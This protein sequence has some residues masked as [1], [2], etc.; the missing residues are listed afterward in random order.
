MPYY[1]GRNG[2]VNMNKC[3]TPFVGDLII[4]K[5]KHQFR[6]TMTE[7]KF[8][9]RSQRQQAWGEIKIFTYAGDSANIY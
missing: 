7:N 8:S 4:P 2:M 5:Y 6:A 9:D 3:I 1:W